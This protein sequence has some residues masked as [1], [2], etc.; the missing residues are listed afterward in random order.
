[1]WSS[2]LWLFEDSGAPPFSSTEPQAGLGARRA[3]LGSKQSCFTGLAEI[4]WA[5]E[6]GRPGDAP[7][8]RVRSLGVGT[9]QGLLLLEGSGQGA[10]GIEDDKETL[11]S[12]GSFVSKSRGGFHVLVL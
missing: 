11:I 12:Q 6:W 7:G 9:A 5:R 1:M 3:S 4:P 8:S 10:Q 2:G